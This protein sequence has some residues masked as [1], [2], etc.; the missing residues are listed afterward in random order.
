MMTDT[1][2]L[3]AVS[4]VAAHSPDQS[5]Q[6]QRLTGEEVACDRAA[7]A[8]ADY[9]RRLGFAES[10]DA[11][12]LAAREVAREA[13]AS[14]P[15]LRRSDASIV[16]ST[17]IRQ[18]VRDI[19]HWLRVLARETDG[20]TRPASNILAAAAARI[21]T[22]SRRPVPVCEPTGMAGQRFRN[23][24][25]IVARWVGRSL[26]RLVRRRKATA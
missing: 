20:R 18:T 4:D 1:L 10:S 7:A 19:D 22:E 6:S 24:P 21:E 15:K 5:R 16:R 26:A 9:L 23:R 2:L 8:V 3:T 12:Q 11:V 25:A 13:A 17:A 14:L